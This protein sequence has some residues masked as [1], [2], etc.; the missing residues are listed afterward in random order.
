MSIL[1][2]DLP[3]QFGPYRLKQKIASGGMAELFLAEVTGPHGFIKPL[4]IKMIHGAFNEDERFLSLFTE[5][6]KIVSGLTHGNIVPIFDFG[7]EEGLMYLAMEFIDGV[8]VA[9]LMDVCRLQ[10]ISLPTE[11]TLFIGVGIAA[12]LSHVHQATTSEGESKIVVHRDVSPQNI[13]LSRSGEVKLCDFGLAATAVRDRVV[14]DEIRGKLR[15]LSPEQANGDGVDPRS[16][17]FSL[18]VVLYELLAGHHPVLFGT[19]VT[20]LQELSGGAGYR[21]LGEACP[22]M[23][24]DIVAAVDR[25]LAFSP[26]DRFENAEEMRAA[27]FKILHADFP[28]FSPQDLAALVIRAQEAAEDVRRS[29]VES[30]ARAKIASFASSTRSPASRRPEHEKRE[31]GGEKK[32][33]PSLAV[34]FVIGLAAAVI[35]AAAAWMLSIDREADAVLTTEISSDHPTKS[36]SAKPRKRAPKAAK[37]PPL[38]RTE[39]PASREGPSADVADSRGETPVEETPGQKS[40][41]GASAAPAPPPASSPANRKARGFGTVNI[42]ASPWADVEIDGVDYTSTPILGLKLRAGRHRATFVNP[43]IGVTKTK[44][45]VVKADETL[46]ILVEME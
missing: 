10:G 36:I 9:T 38:A 19:E 20:V 37:L 6:A 31:K 42:N 35:T 29:D 44:T 30:V 26:D 22:W 11:I 46:R 2:T 15:Y 43:E 32:G 39:E 28:D 5:E 33:R 27:L 1:E 16:D 41:N 17:L 14:D 24:D 25:A 21:S 23:P 12:G 34:I 8:D 3:R 4:V 7:Q 18:G 40:G 45:F 13:L